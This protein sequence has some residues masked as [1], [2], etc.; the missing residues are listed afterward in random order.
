MAGHALRYDNYWFYR[1]PNRNWYKV[2]GELV[3]GDIGP[4]SLERVTDPDEILVLEILF[5]DIQESRLPNSRREG[6]LLSIP[7]DVAEIA[8][9][10]RRRPNRP[11]RG[12]KNPN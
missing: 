5:T 12:P 8:D 3:P 7:A 6:L 10:L 4:E 9:A 11:D 1:A 2:V